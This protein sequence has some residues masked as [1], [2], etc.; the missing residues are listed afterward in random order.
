[1][2]P[3]T[4]FFGSFS[5]VT[6][7]LVVNRYSPYHTVRLPSSCSRKQPRRTAVP[8][9]DGENSQ[10]SDLNTRRIGLDDNAV[11]LDPRKSDNMT[12]TP[13]SCLICQNAVGEAMNANRDRTPAKKDLY[14]KPFSAYEFLIAFREQHAIEI[15]AFKVQTNYQIF[16]EAL[17]QLR[18]MLLGIVDAPIIALEILSGLE[19]TQMVLLSCVTEVTK[20]DFSALSNCSE[21]KDWKDKQADFSR[22]FTRSGAG[23]W[24]RKDILD[25]WDQLLKVGERKATLL[26]A[27]THGSRS[28]STR[29]T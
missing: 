18:M 8:D 25:S 16:K 23:S 15:W 1:M 10:Q 14:P 3:G 11:V 7:V 21:S 13:G 22:K 20:H 24:A 12:T 17:Q 9:V 26:S 19:R 6:F 5:R 27:N 4:G 29:Y 28:L 2:S